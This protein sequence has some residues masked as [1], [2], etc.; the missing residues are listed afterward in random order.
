MYYVSQ[1]E[2]ER[3]DAVAVEFGLEVRQMMELA[4]FFIRPVFHDLGISRDTSVLI[5][6]GP[7][8]KGG[9]GLAAAR[10]LVNT[11]FT[12]DM[13][14]L[15]SEA[16]IS[17]DAYHQ[18][19]LLKYME[20]PRITY[21]AES[22][23]EIQGHL[24]NADVIIDAMIGYNLSGELREPYVYIV[25]QMN[26]STSYVVSYDLPTGVKATDGTIA[27]EAVRANATLTLAAPKRAFTTETGKAYAGTVYVGDL[28][29]PER[30]YQEAYGRGRPRF[31]A[32]GILNIDT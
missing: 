32:D 26:E 17:S 12:V 27:G 5:L 13:V 4:G 20:V 21:E 25:R 8:N 18:L 2:I 29:I 16:H 9:D 7:G 3:L 30:L 24:K 15:S 22:S 23:E 11:G 6:V 31:P 1:T 19:K 10:Q 14:L 28:G